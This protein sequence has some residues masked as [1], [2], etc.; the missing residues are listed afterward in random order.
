MTNLTNLFDLESLDHDEVLWLLAGTFGS[1]WRRSRSEIELPADENFSLRIRYQGGEIRSIHAGPGLKKKADQLAVVE[2]IRRKLTTRGHTDVVRV[3]ML[4]GRAVPGH[5]RSESLSF[6]LSPATLVSSAAL[7]S[8]EHHPFL[9]E[10]PVFSD[11]DIKLRSWRRYK[12]ACE[13]AWLLGVLLHENILVEAPRQ[14]SMWARSADG[15]GTSTYVHESFPDLLVD[16]F[17]S[18]LLP[19][20]SPPLTTVPAETY[21]GN[22]PFRARLG[23]LLDELVLPNDFEDSLR[24][25]LNLSGRDRRRFLQAAMTLYVGRTAWITSISTSFLAYVQAIEAFAQD[26]RFPPGGTKCLSRPLGPTKRFRQVCEAYGAE[27][28]IPASVI[29]RLY[30]TRSS[31]SH[32]ES[33]FELDRSPWG[34]GPVSPAL[35]LGDMDSVEHASRLSKAVAIGWLR[36]KAAKQI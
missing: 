16:A 36:S 19:A 4:A 17:G 1:A 30:D 3:M 25:F 34:L 12:Q 32:G 31:L 10:F 2:S 11:G 20:T 27:A 24:G 15:T 29:R 7:K 5:F 8:G 22:V 18:V 14:R 9:V 21:Y 33:V 35:G 13:W 6:Q 26:L 23:V 28:S